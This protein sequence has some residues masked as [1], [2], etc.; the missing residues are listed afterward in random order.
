MK[1]VETMDGYK[2][3][4]SDDAWIMIRPSGTEPVLRVYVQ[5]PS[6]TEAQAILTAGLKEM[7]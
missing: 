4:L 5:A 6:E 2:F 3:I 7:A 1:R